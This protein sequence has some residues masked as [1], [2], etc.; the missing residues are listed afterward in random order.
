M[1]ALIT[2]SRGF[3]GGYLRSELDAHGYSVFGLDIAADEQTIAGDITN[4]VQLRDILRA[5][6]PD[7]VFH[8]AGQANVALSWQIPQKTFELNAI[9][10]INLLE[11]LRQ[12]KVDA[13]V[14]GIGSSDQY[15]SLG[16]LGQNVTEETQMRPQSLYAVSKKAQEEIAAVYARAYGMQICMTRSF[17]HAGAGQKQGFMISDFASGIA[18]V[19]CGKAEYLSV[20]NLSAKRDFTHVKDIVRAYRLLSEVGKSGEVYNIG[21]QVVYSAQEI[22]D[23]LCAMA[24]CKI[25]VRQDAAK[26]RPSDT[27]V[28]CCDHSKLTRDTG[29]MPEIY[30]DVILREVLEEWRAITRQEA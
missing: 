22:L 26:M 20:G 1:R 14:V 17:N 6:Q 28:I 7:V 3:V 18:R 2:G 4:P 16:K 5:V 10:L 21:S 30:I 9:G 11:A 13:R 24:T 19:E 27:P 29:W 8:L 12:E 25:P 15:G 23:R